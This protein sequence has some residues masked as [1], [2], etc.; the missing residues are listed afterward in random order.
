M[1]QKVENS[2][3]VVSFFAGKCQ[4]RFQLIL[5]FFSRWRSLLEA[6]ARI[7]ELPPSYVHLALQRHHSL[8]QEGKIRIKS[9]FSSNPRFSVIT[10]F[11]EARRL[12]VLCAFF[13]PS[14][15][16]CLHHT[17]PKPSRVGEGISWVRRRR[18]WVC[19]PCWLGALCLAYWRWGFRFR[20]GFPVVFCL[21]WVKGRA[22]K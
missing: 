3:P 5:W 4:L 16:H 14:G 1:L 22:P 2:Q 9:A 18:E 10:L 7:H 6:L 20:N 8:H 11:T 12:E 15:A 17:R 21:Q 13:A 19:S